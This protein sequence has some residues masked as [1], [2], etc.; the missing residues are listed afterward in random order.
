MIIII[1]LLIIEFLLFH[2]AL[3]RERDYATDTCVGTDLTLEKDQTKNT[4]KPRVDYA[5]W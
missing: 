3:L 5:L 1:I 2:I 4:R